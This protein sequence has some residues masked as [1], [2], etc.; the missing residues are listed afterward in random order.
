VASSFGES[1]APPAASIRWGRSFFL[2]HPHRKR[3]RQAEIDCFSYFR[4]AP[5]GIMVRRTRGGYTRA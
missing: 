3:G 1:N 4:L 2:C 5:F